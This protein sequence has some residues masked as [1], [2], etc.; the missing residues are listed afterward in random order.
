MN[1]PGQGVPRITLDCRSETRNEQ[2]PLAASISITRFSCPRYRPRGASPRRDTATQSAPTRTALYVFGG[3]DEMG[4]H[5]FSLFYLDIK[6]Q[7]QWYL[8]LLDAFVSLV[9]QYLVSESLCGGPCLDRCRTRANRRKSSCRVNSDGKI[10]GF[11][12]STLKPESTP[13]IDDGGPQ[14]RESFQ[15]ASRHLPFPLSSSL[16]L[17]LKP[18]PQPCI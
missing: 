1:P 3:V 13:L 2:S 6:R 11:L 4:G 8:R 9:G 7:L 14:Y 15:T 17:W 16:R 12:Q 10:I 18:Q 5:L